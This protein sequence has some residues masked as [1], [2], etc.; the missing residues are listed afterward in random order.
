MFHLILYIS[1]IPS[2]TADINRIIFLNI[3]LNLLRFQA[4]KYH[5]SN[6]G[7]FALKWWVL[8][9]I[10]ILIINVIINV[11]GSRLN[12]REIILDHTPT[13]GDIKKLK[14]FINHYILNEMFH[15]VDHLIMD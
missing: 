11:S 14:N 4:K 8:H 1:A 12:I 9:T 7:L 10:I 3:N 5:I 6:T 13:A 15:N 2:L